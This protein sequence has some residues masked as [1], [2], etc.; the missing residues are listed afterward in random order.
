MGT[1]CLNL[2]SY[3]NFVQRT[4][5]ATHSHQY[6]VKK[7]KKNLTQLFNRP[8]WYMLQVTSYECILTVEGNYQTVGATRDGDVIT[9]GENTVSKNKRCF[10]HVTPSL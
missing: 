9:C 2:G 4:E 8:S 6:Y 10:P 3:D 7:E 1:S 5:T